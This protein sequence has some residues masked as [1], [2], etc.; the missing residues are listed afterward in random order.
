MYSI[1][2]LI[3]CVMASAAVYLSWRQRTTIAWV[4]ALPLL[5][6]SAFAFSRAGGWEQAVFLAL[7]LPGII[8]W[9]G[10]FAERSFKPFDRKKPV[11]RALD[12]SWHKAAGHITTGAILLIAQLGL[13][14]ILAVSISRLLPVEDAG[15]LAIC[16]VLQP[17]FWAG[18]MF[19]FMSRNKHWRALG[20]Q[21]ALTGVFGVTL[22][23]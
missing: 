9:A 15:Q 2:A 8:V 12:I 6:L 10:I 14:L 22:V 3:S 16:V 5:G 4:S 21:L 18:M 17:L 19:H 7:F 1:L 20:W 23:I 11:L 13:S